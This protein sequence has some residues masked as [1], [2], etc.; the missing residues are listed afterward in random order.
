MDWNGNAGM[1]MPAEESATVVEKRTMGIGN[2]K[3]LATRFALICLN[4]IADVFGENR[5]DFG[6]RKLLFQQGNRFYVSS[7]G[8]DGFGDGSF[9]YPWLTLS[10]AIHEAEPWDTICIE[11]RECG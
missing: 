5:V 4:L 10:K 8:H 7:N 2:L 6:L 11:P 1:A 3:Y 9:R